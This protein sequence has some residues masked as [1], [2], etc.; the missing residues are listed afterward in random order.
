[1]PPLDQRYVARLDDF[2]KSLEGIVE[3]LKQDTKKKNVDNVNKM[4]SNMK[5]GLGKVAKDMETLIKSSK[6]IE[7]Q[8]DK[9]LEEI[10]ASRKAKETGMFGNIADVDNKRKILDAV[11]VITLIA[12]GVLAIGLAFKIIGHVDFLSV[13][14]I[15]LA[16][17]FISG[18]FVLVAER[19]KEMNQKQ[20]IDAGKMMV[21]M[22]MS[23][24]ISSLAL[25]LAATISVGKAISIVFVAAAMGSSLVL[26]AHAVQKSKIEPKDY[27]K[28]ALLPLVLPVIAI[29]LVVSSLILSRIAP[30]TF[31][32]VMT[33][34]FVATAVGTSLFLMAKAIEKSKIEPKDMGKFFLLPLML[35]ALALGIVLS[36]IILKGVQT[37]TFM[38]MISAIF[39]AVTIGVMVFLMKPI[40]EKMKEFTP[41]QIALTSVL[42]AALAAGIVVASW[43]LGGMRFFSFREAFS[44][45]ITSL[46]IGL[47]VLMLTPAVYILKS[48]KQEDMITAMKNVV[49]IAGGIFLS[50]WL[51]SFG[52]YDNVPSWQWAVGA[53]LSI[54][55]FAGTIWLLNKMNL[56]AKEML[57][58]AAMVVGISIVIA[59]TS[60]IL[61]MGRYEDYPTLGWAAGVGLSLVAFGAGMLAL[62]A[63]ILLT[64][65]AAAGAMA[66]GALA[67]LLV[68]G[69]IVAVSYILGAGKYE[70]YPSFDWAMG[71]GLSLTA[72]GAVM[73]ASGPFLPLL[74]LGALS[75]GVVAGTI[76]GI[77]NIIASG[78]YDKGPTEDWAKGVSLLMKTFAD[79][80]I[81]TAFYPN[82]LLSRCA[83]GLLIIARNIVDISDVL[84]TGKYGEGP[85]EEWAKGTTGTLV[86][87]AKI[88]MLM[89]FVMGPLLILGM[90]SMM[91]V[92]GTIVGVSKILAQGDYKN[93]PP[94]DWTK[95]T[96]KILLDTAGLILL[97]GFIPL[98]FFLS[99]LLS[100]GAIAN[101]IVSVSKKLSEGVYTGGPTEEWA[102]GVGA[103][104][105]AFAEGIAALESTGSILG[106]IFGSES[107]NDKIENIANAMKTAAVTL[108]KDFDWTNAKNYP[109]EEWSAG[110]GLAIK[111]FAE[112]IA[113]LQ[114]TD[115]GWFDKSYEEKI[116]GIALS[117]IVAAE[118]LATYDWTKAKG[119]PSTEWSTG[120]G[121]AIN[122]FAG[123]LSEFE[124]ASG[125]FSD[126]LE[127]SIKK[128][129]KGL[130]AA[131][132]E[133]G[134]Y[135]W[136]K[137]NNYP[138][139]QW[140]EGVGLAIGTFVKYLVEIEKNDIG[141]GDLRILNRTIDAM[142]SAAWKFGVSE[143]LTGGKIWNT[144]PKEGWAKRVGDAIGTF[145]QYL[146][147]IEKNDIGR[148]DLKV[149][150]KTID[151]MINAAD[152]FSDVDVWASPP[153]AWGENV[154][155]S[156]TAVVK[157]I[158]LLQG[159]EDFDLLDDAADAIVNFSRRIE[160][161]LKN[162]DMYA[163]GGLFD[164]FSDSMK[165][166]SESL[167]T[168]VG[169]A[170]GLNA[171]GD[172][173]LKIS[174][175]GTSTTDS[176]RMLSKSIS[177]LSQ[178][179]E[180]VDM[181]SIDK[182]SKFS[183]GILVLSLIDDKKLEDAISLIDKK[184]NDIV[185]ILSESTPRVA[186]GGLEATNVATE[187]GEEE[188][189]TTDKD[190]FYQDLLDAVNRIDGNVDII[191]K[192]APPQPS[193]QATTDNRVSSPVAGAGSDQT[194]KTWT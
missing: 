90:I 31:G 146:V 181:E 60:W 139:K 48:I 98:P 186:T 74:I 95:S 102:K 136:N 37:L 13:I 4:L 88:S 11:K 15:G 72:F 64:E 36:S 41:K 171:L 156:I 167:P 138:K 92:A 77:S 166:L 35:P 10:K 29:G 191:A 131:A 163:K 54:T 172:A 178:S 67:V 70:K 80:M 141:R 50:S 32:Q 56:S 49:I 100:M 14:A 117:M 38:Q 111:T 144:G 109:S 107:Y 130:V 94:E 47:S 86:H 182:L 179:L 103:S 165:R 99:G 23:I 143:F 135:D 25:S 39:V 45:V 9:I 118:T 82:A 128:L 145:V 149:L 7:S 140:V 87:F 129:A 101:A 190:K 55:T 116:K 119:Y 134:D 124:K 112:G 194:N 192:G 150:N 85:S 170:D 151:S 40:I 2:T 142:V 127:T 113:A 59:A 83:A 96:S 21:I 132:E 78:N 57:T 61:S 162:Q 17:V 125:F 75:M 133:I 58:G 183:S 53:G 69:A 12:G 168:S 5:D 148:G 43:I 1:M 177:E 137:A 157:S 147:E 155:K 46:A 33:T 42:V 161:I 34:I 76:V 30:M 176:I 120:V 122:A 89:G 63:I 79:V 52:K 164:T 185:K 51:L 6:K 65:G 160:K 68:S 8:N 19:T 71:V 187:G 62:G 159:V 173:L 18:A 152:R 189:V 24:A 73:V 106:K 20:L 66:V 123:P 169:M 175:M 22:S 97:F 16:V 44:M 110:V 180:D 26:M 84:S 108:G 158:Q 105:Q 81:E 28:M 93:G 174:S 126:D 115:T 184:K 153:A 27:L 3:L 121:N 104:M 154:E 91:S 114:D 193:G 188:T